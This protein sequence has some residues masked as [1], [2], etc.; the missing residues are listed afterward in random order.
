MAHVRTGNHRAA[1]LEVLLMQT[2]MKFFFLP[3]LG[4]FL[5]VVFCNTGNCQTLA[6]AEAEPKVAAE[7]KELSPTVGIG[8]QKCFERLRFERPILL[9]H[10]GDGSDRVFVLEQG[11]RILVFENGQ[12]PTKAEVF[13]DASALVSRKG[14]EEGLL[15]LAFHP[16]YKTN[17]Q[18]FVS[19]SSKKKDMHSVVSRFNVREDDPSQADPDSEEIILT[20]RQPYRNHNGGD[21]KF[22]LDGYLYISFGDG[23]SKNDP[24]SNGQ[25]LETWLG[26]ILRIDVDH[27]A[28]GKKYSVP[29][30]NPFVDPSPSV[31]TQDVAPEIWAYGLRNV[32]RFSFDRQTGD[33]WAADVGQNKIEEVNIITAGGNYG[34]NR[35]EADEIFH[36][37]TSL[38]QGKAIE[39]VATYHHD[40]GLSITGGHVYRGQRFPELDGLYFYADY[41][42][43]NLWSL[44]KT[45][46]GY[47]STLVRQTGRSI[48]GFGEDQAGE[49]YACSFDGY[50]YRLVPSEKPANVFTK[51]EQKLSQT[52]IF[53]SLKKQTF[54][55]AYSRYE[56]NAPFW[57]DHAIK[58]RY[59]KVPQGKSLGYQE[60]GTW[61]IPVGTRIVKHFQNI[62]K[63]P[64]ETRLIVRTEDGW[65]AATY[66]WNNKRSDADLLPNGKQFE[67][68][69]PIKG[70]KKWK[71]IT[72]HAPSSSECASCHTEAA[73][74]VLGMNTAQLNR[75][76]EGKESNQ[77]LQWIAD[78]L[79][80]LEVFDSAAAPKYCYPFDESADLETRARVLLEVNCAMCHRPNGPGN[81]NIDLRFETATD[82]TKMVNV[83]PAQSDLGVAGSMILK[84]GS[85]KK[86]T[87]LQRMETLGQ[88]RM[89][90]IGSTIVDRQGVELIGQWIKSL[91]P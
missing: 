43:G 52:D 23:G 76:Q 50:I 68:W 65:E 25:N 55:D 3:F 19:Y 5:A 44:R 51:W 1:Q 86:S 56:V 74:Y 59:F 41:V 30:D 75:A 29:D 8:L 69:R 26:A 79:V 33:L 46:A 53:S 35:F 66:V 37:E 49:V 40:L 72:W 31:E 28:D 24:H 63:K 80:D 20:L 15:G 47:K 14:N 13:L 6:E 48:A 84:P 45:E 62:D 67:L 64:I 73:G 82:Q 27:Q 58:H 70:S 83:R 38:A 78:G 91:A 87:L 57:S 22:G 12:S 21:I 16:N 34:W 77:I 32:W 42:S 90:T 2:L 88:G 60:S 18:F 54:S 36:E 39:P 4:C 9:T 85:P 10:A 81:A 71:P 7:A 11:G 17:G 89:P 61:T